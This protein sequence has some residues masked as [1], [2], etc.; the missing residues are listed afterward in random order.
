MDS[1]RSVCER[2]LPARDAPSTEKRDMDMSTEAV[3]ES[4]VP[5]LSRVGT[6]VPLF[7]L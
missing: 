3:G 2:R 1:G 6:A 5:K 7:D 4:F